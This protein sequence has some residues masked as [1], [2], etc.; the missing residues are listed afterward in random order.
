MYR[1]A[2]RLRLTERDHDAVCALI[3][4]TGSVARAARMLGIDPTTCAKIRDGLDVCDGTAALVRARIVD[5]AMGSVMVG[6]IR[7]RC[8]R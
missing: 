6:G 2:P 3:R 5:L 7:M 8:S 1:D 4:R